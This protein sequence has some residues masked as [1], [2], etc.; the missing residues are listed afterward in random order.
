MMSRYI[1]LLAV[2]AIPAKRKRERETNV[3]TGEQRPLEQDGGDD[4]G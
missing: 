1:Q 4:E 2:Y 3:R